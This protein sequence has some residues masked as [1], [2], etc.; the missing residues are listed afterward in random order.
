MAQSAEHAMYVYFNQIKTQLW[1]LWCLSFK[2]FWLKNLLFHGNII[3]LL[4]CTLQSSVRP[5]IPVRVCN[6]C[7]YRL[8][9]LIPRDKLSHLL[10]KRRH[11]SFD[12]L[13]VCF[14]NSANKTRLPTIASPPFFLFITSTLLLF[15]FSSGVLKASVWIMV[16]QGLTEGGVN[17][18][19][20][21]L[22]LL[23]VG[24]ECNTEKGRVPTPRKWFILYYFLPLFQFSLP[25]LHLTLKTNYWFYFWG[26]LQLVKKKG[27]N[28]PWKHVAIFRKFV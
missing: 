24:E 6:I 9:S 20:T 23:L 15:F 16:L 27:M 19:T 10:V 12:C 2:L 1:W 18:L 3:L 21:G 5:C 28:K 25:C 22:V 11:V 26:L 13:F 4:S 8:I 17:G 14:N 7:T